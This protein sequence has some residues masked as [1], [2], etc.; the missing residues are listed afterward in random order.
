VLAGLWAASCNRKVFIFGIF[1]YRIIFNCF[2]QFFEQ[3]SN[4]L[5]YSNY[6]NE[7]FV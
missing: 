4:S 6:S 7:K 3:I 2:A 5:F 1:F